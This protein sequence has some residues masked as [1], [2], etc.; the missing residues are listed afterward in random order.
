MNALVYTGP[1]QVEVKQV[2]QPKCTE[3]K[4]VKIKVHYCGVCGSDIGIYKGNHPRA[5]APL[6]L[7]HEFV[8]EIA[9]IKFPRGKFKVGDRVASYPL[10]SCQNCLPC[11]TGRAH[12]CKTLGLYGVDQDGGMAEYICVPEEVL[13]L[14]DEKV[15]MK[16]AAIVEPLAVIIRELHQAGF[17]PLDCAVVLGAG[18]IGLLTAIMLRKMGASKI[19]IADIQEERVDKCHALGFMAINPE[20]E[21]IKKAVSLMTN[22]EGADIVFECTGNESV[23]PYITNITR[24][25]GTICLTGVHNAPRKMDLRDVNFKE[26]HLVGTRVYT[27]SEFQSACEYLKEIQNDTAEVITHVIPLSESEK[28]FEFIADEKNRAVKVLLDCR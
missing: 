15:G 27:L 5:K 14:I 4:N 13:F 8:G 1:C 25:S 7:G 20:R 22:T 3:Q 19:L 18:T 26:L 16:N 17:K 12:I 6:I 23:M 2:Q 10:L 21:D 11:K 24:I 28:I 9:E